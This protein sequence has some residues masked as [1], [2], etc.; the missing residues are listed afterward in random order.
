MKRLAFILALAACGGPEPGT[1]A[2][3]PEPRPPS[4]ARSAC[5]SRAEY[6]ALADKVATMQATCAQATQT[7]GVCAAP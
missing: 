5:I 1:V 3:D 4:V 2:A 7:C 6:D